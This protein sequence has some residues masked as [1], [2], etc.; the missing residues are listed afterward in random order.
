MKSR[1]IISGMLL[2]VFGFVFAGCTRTY[3]FVN[4]S[5]FAITIVPEYGDD[6]QIQP[7]VTKSFESKHSTMTINYSPSNY[8]ESGMSQKNYFT[9]TNKNLYFE[10]SGG[11]II[12]PPD[13]WETVS[14][15][16]LVNKILVG[17]TENNFAPNMNFIEENNPFPQFST[18]V[19]ASARQ[20]R[21]LGF[22][23]VARDEFVTDSGIEGVKFET[24]TTNLLQIYY[25][26][27]TRR[28]TAFLITCSAPL[29]SETDYGEIFDSC[30]KTLEFTY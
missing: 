6:F 15:P 9:F 21:D 27:D 16:G 30:V 8:V 7:G 29:Q 22:R 28:Q 25:I 20:I 11:F 1:K 24:N 18:Y 4:N 26:F 14:Y 10:E 19:D 3:T 12:F 23:I 13:S 5:S 17:E 2:L